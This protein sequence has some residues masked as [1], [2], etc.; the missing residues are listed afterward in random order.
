M[1]KNELETVF[2]GL[3]HLMTV[4]DEEC[5]VKDANTTFCDKYA[6]TSDKLKNAHCKDVNGILGSVCETCPIKET[7]DKDHTVVKRN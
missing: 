4:I 7:F 3:T 2:N 1:S 6:L 5:Y